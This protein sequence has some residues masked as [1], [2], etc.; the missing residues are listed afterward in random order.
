MITQA[1]YAGVFCARYT[2]IADEQSKYNLFFKLFYI[3]SSFYTIGIMRWLY[4]RTREKELAWKM[5]A[6]VLGGA[7]LISPFAMLIFE[8]KTSWSLFTVSAPRHI[9]IYQYLSLLVA[10]GSFPDP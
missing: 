3:L 6:A 9:A 8:K 7:L 10:M 1:L 4:P 2:D 5:G